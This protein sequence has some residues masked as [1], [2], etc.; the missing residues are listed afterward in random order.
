[1]KKTRFLATCLLL[2]V[3][4]VQAKEIAIVTDKNTINGNLKVNVVTHNKYDYESINLY[5]ENTDG[6]STLIGNYVKGALNNALVPINT[7]YKTTLIRGV[8]NNPKIVNEGSEVYLKTNLPYYTVEGNEI[9]WSYLFNG[10]GN[11]TKVVWTITSYNEAKVQIDKKVYSTKP[12]PTTLGLGT[13]IVELEYY[14]LYGTKFAN[15]KTVKIIGKEVYSAKIVLNDEV[16]DIEDIDWSYTFNGIVKDAKWYINDEFYE[17]P[18]KRMKEGNYT[19]KLE[20]YDELDTLYSTTKSLKVTHKAS[21]DDLVRGSFPEGTTISTTA[22]TYSGDLQNLLKATMYAGWTTTQYSALITLVF[23][24]PIDITMFEI[25]KQSTPACTQNIV[26]TGYSEKGDKI[27]NSVTFTFQSYD[28]RGIAE[29][30][31]LSNPSQVYS[32]YDN[33]GIKACKK[34][35]L[36][37]NANKSWGAMKHIGLGYTKSK[38]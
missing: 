1:M 8:I 6:K 7:E 17:E 13:H 33:L 2:G 4:S 20:L 30:I 3:T 31:L 32:S 35:T 18:P 15:K 19:V 37:F 23:P 27:G 14:D 12:L 9:E 38:I 10:L 22:N 11:A 5:Q 29:S 26:I 16:Q 25:G 24:E 36:D 28:N 21:L 34:L